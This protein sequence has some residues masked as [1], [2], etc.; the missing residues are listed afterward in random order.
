MGFMRWT[1]AGLCLKPQ[2]KLEFVPGAIGSQQRDKNTEVRGFDTAV[3]EVP[4]FLHVG[5]SVGK[6]ARVEEGK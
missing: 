2:E 6:K 5:W 3:L 4:W 1:R